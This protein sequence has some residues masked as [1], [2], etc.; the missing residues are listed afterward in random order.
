MSEFDDPLDLEETKVLAWELMQE[1]ER[2][3]EALRE[4]KDRIVEWAGYAS[5]YFREKHDL[6][7]DLA[8]ID[9]ALKGDSDG[10]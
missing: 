5:P 6:E 10:T 9:A 2:L 8:H 1:N 7:G 4:A 3:R